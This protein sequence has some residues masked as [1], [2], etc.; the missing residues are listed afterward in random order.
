MKEHLTTDLHLNHAKLVTKGFRPEGYEEMIT[1]DWRTQVQDDDVVYCL[2]DVA[3][4]KEGEAHERIK[5]LPGRKILIRGNH[6]KQKDAWYLSHGWDE[7]HDSLRLNRTVNG[8]H[9]R[10]ILTHVP[11][12]VDNSWDL[13]IHGHFHNDSHRA[14]TEEMLAIYSNKHRLLSI[15][16]VDYKMVPFQE[17]LE[18][19]VIQVGLPV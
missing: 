3:M 7:I 16:C 11:I 17:F 13:N 10:V 1:S 2:G 6:D 15:E 9:T 14:K 5:T 19:K 18:G 12:A 8:R 4:G